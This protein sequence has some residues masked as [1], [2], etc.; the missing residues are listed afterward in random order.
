MT[1]A[2]FP[3]LSLAS[4][5]E[6]FKQI[7]I[8]GPF[9]TEPAS[10]CVFGDRDGW[11]V[12]DMHIARSLLTSTAGQKS[13]PEHSQRLLGG[14][15]VLHADK[16]RNVKRQLI[17]AMGIEA[18]RRHSLAEHL[19]A[20]MARGPLQPG[21]L[22]EALSSSML[23][24]LTGQ[25]PGSVDGARLRKLV[26]E[27]WSSLER[28]A[29]SGGASPAA[30]HDEL[31]TF[32]AELIDG[33]GSGFLECLRS[34]DWTTDRIAQEL[35]A[36]VLAGWG[37]TTAATLS[38]VSLG[39]ASFSASFAIDEVLRLYPPSFMIART[40]VEPHRALPFVVGD[41]VLASPWLIHRSVRGWPRPQHYDPA[42]W[43]EQTGLHWFLPFGLGPRRC[44]AA[45]FAR[46]QITA[47]I[48]MYAD[49]HA[50]RPPSSE[51]T[52]VESR[53]PALVPHWE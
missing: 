16:V 30:L 51:L 10:R 18:R 33:P 43:R 14:V 26:F 27:T 41:L 42:Q 53:S 7:R 40:I 32:I 49:A 31:A 36:M 5:P 1:P 25:R 9:L 3:D 19:K 11:I 13:R 29:D 28:P 34:Q 35:R 52:L 15:G 22:T 4:R 47:A 8:R 39:I 12:S 38:T 45:T 48:E 2:Q 46:A 44:P 50:V 24:Q 20:T 17:S 23:A 6:L 21:P 37:S